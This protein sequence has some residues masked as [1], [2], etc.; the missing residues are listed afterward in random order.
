MAAEERDKYYQQQVDRQGNVVVPLSARRSAYDGAAMKDMPMS[1]P[2]GPYRRS[3]LRAET[4]Q[5]STRLAAIALFLAWFV[6]WPVGTTL[7]GLESSGT[8]QIR[9]GYDAA[10]PIL[11]ITTAALVWAV[12]W[13]LAVGM[14]LEESARQYTMN[15]AQGA[16]FPQ[17]D[18]ARAQVDALNAEID[19]ALSRLADAESLIRQQVR[20]INSAGSAIESG[21]TRSTERLESERKALMELAEEMNR[22]AERFAETIAERTKMNVGEQENMEARLADKE[23]EL[24][25]QLERL[26]AVSAK[27]LDRFEQL[28]SA[29]E[30]RSTSLQSANAEATE[31]QSAVASQ[32]EENA[33]RITSMQSELAAQSARLETLMKDQRRRA[34]RLAKILTEQ[35]G[36]LPARPADEPGETA[37]SRRRVPWKD[38]L[39]TVEERIP[40]PIKGRNVIAVP[41]SGAEPVPDAMDRL[42]NRIHNF[43]L[44]ML[45]QIYDGPNHAELDRFERGERQ[46]FA[47]SLLERDGDDIRQRVRQ[48]VDRNPVFRERVD[49]FLR[50]FDTL[51]EPLSAEDG[52]E[53]AIETY[54]AS[55]IGRLYVITGSA[56]D[57][58]A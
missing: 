36:R 26:E 21:A 34:D 28:A 57:H 13:I 25:S 30:D 7:A 18:A 29:M 15:I 47:K 32:I 38:I 20:A 23:R 16:S 41:P 11:A 58:F 51:L 4:V 56:V 9:F 27:S 52:G 37:T 33:K 46:L 50:D 45:T 19:Q 3:R 14:R 48:E 53:E 43:S 12:G 49:E 22:E 2:A 6:L 35:A 24:S 39:A 10:V 17:T 31:R 5:R 40:S 42:I 55:P 54:L 8:F 44:V 1:P